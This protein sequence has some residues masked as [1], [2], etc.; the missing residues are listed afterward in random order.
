[1]PLRNPLPQFSWEESHVHFCNTGQYTAQALS[2]MMDSPATYRFEAARKAAEAAGG[3]LV[4]M[5]ATPNDGPG[6]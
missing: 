2:A 4:A 5:Y 6:V 3:K 1:M